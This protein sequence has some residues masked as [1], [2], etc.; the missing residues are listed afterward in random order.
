MAI[1]ASLQDGAQM[2]KHELTREPRCIQLRPSTT[3]R[4]LSSSFL[5]FMFRVL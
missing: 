1:A 5:E 4:L 3:R 2:Q